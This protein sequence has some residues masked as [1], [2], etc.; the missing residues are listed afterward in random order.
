MGQLLEK[1]YNMHIQKG[2]CTLI[3]RNG[4]FI[5]KVKMTPNCLFPPRIKHDQFSC[6]SFIIPND[7]GYGI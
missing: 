5:T 1:G 4:R 6:L 7:D 3:D 2:Y